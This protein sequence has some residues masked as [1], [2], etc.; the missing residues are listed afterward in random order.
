MAKLWPTL[1]Q[2]LGWNFNQEKGSTIEQEQQKEGTQKQGQPENEKP[3]GARQ[4]QG[5][6]QTDTRPETGRNETG[7]VLEEPIPC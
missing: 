1:K 5:V 4:P 3:A 2:M 7:R 6:A